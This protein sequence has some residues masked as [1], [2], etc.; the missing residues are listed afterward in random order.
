MY[1]PIYRLMILYLHKH[2]FIKSNGLECTMSLDYPL[3]GSN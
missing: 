1:F 3:E 2:L